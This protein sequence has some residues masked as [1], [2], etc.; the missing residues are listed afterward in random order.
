MRVG[1]PWKAIPLKV[2]PGKRSGSDLASE[3]DKSLSKLERLVEAQ[4]DVQMNLN[5][6]NIMDME[7][8]KCEEM[9]K[10]MIKEVELIR[11]QTR[12]ELSNADEVVPT[13]RQEQQQTRRRRKT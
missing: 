12:G 1:T 7:V 4:E 10:E 5:A 13:Q 3:P 8:K 6:P 11:D 9:K 2:L